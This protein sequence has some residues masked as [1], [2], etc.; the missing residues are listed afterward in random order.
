[1]TVNIEL[2]QNGGFPKAAIWLLRWLL[3]WSGF[4]LSTLIFSA[5]GGGGGGNLGFFSSVLVLTLSLTGVAGFLAAELPIGGA[6][7]ADR[8]LLKNFLLSS[9]LN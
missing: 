2:N 7:N 6:P 1:M 3:T 9:P 5:G 8:L 4:I